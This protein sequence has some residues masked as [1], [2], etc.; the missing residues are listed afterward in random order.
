MQE[1]FITSNHTQ[2]RC[3][4]PS[5]PSLGDAWIRL[6]VVYR[7]VHSGVC[8]MVGS[9]WLHPVGRQRTAEYVE[10]R[11]KRDD[12]FYQQRDVHGDVG[13]LCAVLTSRFVAL[14]LVGSQPVTCY[15]VCGRGAPP[16]E[17]YCISSSQP[18]HCHNSCICRD[19]C[20]TVFLSHQRGSSHHRHS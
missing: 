14:V 20:V 10:L 4:R 8:S 12:G 19:F 1:R 7:D 2:L 18:S 17:K 6:Y 13:N 11:A 3:L 5:G 16:L 9:N 15:L